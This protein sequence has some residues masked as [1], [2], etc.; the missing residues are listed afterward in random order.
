MR[1]SRPRVPKL[2]QKLSSVLD[3]RTKHPVKPPLAQYLL[4]SYVVFIHPFVV[5]VVRRLEP[6]RARWRALKR[7]SIRLYQKT[8]S[9]RR[10]D[11][12]FFHLN[13][14]TAAYSCKTRAVRARMRLSIAVEHPGYLLLTITECFSEYYVSGLREM[15]ILVVPCTFFGISLRC[16]LPLR[17]VGM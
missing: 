5:D 2:K 6:P 3:P 15:E 14:D 8:S 13:V 17:E 10:R 9:G 12:H 1:V 16:C 11:K 7:S 4:Y